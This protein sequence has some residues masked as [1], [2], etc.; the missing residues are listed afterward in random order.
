MDNTSISK[1]ELLQIT[2]ISYG[3]LYRWKRENLIPEEWFEKRSSFTGQETWFPREKI[4]ERIRT[5]QQKKD[6]SSLE[7]LARLL[8]PEQTGIT[9]RISRVTAEDVMDPVAGK[10]FRDHLKQEFCSFWEACV[11]FTLGLARSRGLL[12]DQDLTRLAQSLPDWDKN[13]RS[14]AYKLYII[15]SG[16]TNQVILGAKEPPV[17]WDKAVTVL[18]AFDLDEQGTVLKAKINAL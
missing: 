17:L 11:L 1:K 15:R 7:D 4:L 6:S 3:Q 9:Y 13:Y 10:L 18:A 2:G 5:I 12:N 16:V 14:G 8:S